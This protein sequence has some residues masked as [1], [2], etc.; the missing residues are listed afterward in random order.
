MAVLEGPGVRSVV[1]ADGRLLQWHEYG[2]PAGAPCLYLPGTPASG[3]AG[4]YYDDAA[5][6]AGVRLLS[7]DKPGYGGSAYQPGRTLLGFAADVEQL[8]LSLGLRRFAVLGE[9]GGGP[10]ALAV[11][12]RLPDLLTVALVAAGMGPA[13]QP[14]VQDGMKPE[15]RRLMTLARRAPW[16]LRA[17]MSLTRRALRDTT[18]RERLVASLLAQAGP[19]DRRCLAEM[20]SR[21]DITAAARDALRSSSRAA[22]GELAMLAAPWGFDVG[23]ISC[24]VELWHGQQDVNVPAAVA[25]QLASQLPN[26]TAHVLPDEGHAI[27]WS[28]RADLMS[29]V[30]RAAADLPA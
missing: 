8:A 28:R 14:W 16:A 9:S 23:E 25:E 20:A 10:H 6:R 26:A 12:H 3:L 7:V 15:N 2:D 13:C 22:A 18:R 29:S 24:R 27:G 5:R 1:L 21:H 17:P 30:T 4:A 11:A 19:A